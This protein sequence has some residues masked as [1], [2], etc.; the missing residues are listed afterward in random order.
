[1]GHGVAGH[2]FLGAGLNIHKII[3][4]VELCLEVEE[5]EHGCL[6]CIVFIY[7]KFDEMFYL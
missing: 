1:M 7:I 6:G 2:A 5:L 3:V 4:K